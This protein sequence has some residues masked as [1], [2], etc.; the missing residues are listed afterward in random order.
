MI[1]P[2]DK[3]LK[4]VKMDPDAAELLVQLAGGIRRQGDYLSGLVRAAA[5]GKIIPRSLT[6]IEIL[7]DQIKALTAEVRQLHKERDKA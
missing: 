6:P 4:T 5:D 3:V 7:Q 2:M 1:T